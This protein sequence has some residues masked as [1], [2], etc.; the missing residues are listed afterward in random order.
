M[1]VT[2]AATDSASTLATLHATSVAPRPT[3][4]A[5]PS[6]RYWRTQLAVPQ[7]ELAEMARVSIHTIQRLEAGGEA[8]LST[9]RRLA[10]ALEIEPP[11]LMSQPPEN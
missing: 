3:L 4:V 6:L 9:V 7:R 10:I 8:R 1:L 5:T 2:T 11:V